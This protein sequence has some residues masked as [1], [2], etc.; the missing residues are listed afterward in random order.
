MLMKRPSPLPNDAP[1]PFWWPSCRVGR[2]ENLAG[3]DLM[4]GD[5]AGDYM[6]DNTEL[7]SVCQIDLAG[8]KALCGALVVANRIRVLVANAVRMAHP[9]TRVSGT[10]TR[11]DIDKSGWYNYTA[12]DYRAGDYVGA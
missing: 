8:Q 3:D 5:T 4:S 1:I 9:M 11:G 7:I 12:S 6:A 2:V 10:D